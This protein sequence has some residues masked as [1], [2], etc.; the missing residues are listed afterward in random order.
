LLGSGRRK[1][2]PPLAACSAGNDL[3]SREDYGWWNDLAN[4]ICVLLRCF[5]NPINLVY[6]S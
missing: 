5:T 3:Y 6:S 1:G 4:S 2:V